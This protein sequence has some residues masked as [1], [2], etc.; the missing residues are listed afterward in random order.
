[1]NN[2]W[3]APSDLYA[4]MAKAAPWQHLIIGVQLSVC[5]VCTLLPNTTSDQFLTI[6]SPTKGGIHKPRR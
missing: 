4:H 5:E 1:M 6:F 3:A 2:K